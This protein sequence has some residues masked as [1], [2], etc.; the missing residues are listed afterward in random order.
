MTELTYGG[1]CSLIGLTD[2]W[3]DVRWH[4]LARTDRTGLLFVSVVQPSY[5]QP[6]GLVIE[7]STLCVKEL[8]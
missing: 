4:L 7:K 1:A 5:M 8:L 2:D 3:I 6:S